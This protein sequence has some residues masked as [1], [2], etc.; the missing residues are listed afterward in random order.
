MNKFEF[1]NLTPFKWFVLENFPFIEADFDCLTEWQLFCKLGKEINKIIDSQNTVGTAME[2]FSQAFIR[3]ENYVNNYFDNLDVQEEI[4]NKL[5]DMVEQ[6]TLQEIIADYIN[7]KAIFGYDNVNDMKQATNLI[8]GSYAKTLGY[9]SKNDGGGSLYKIRNITNEDIVDEMYIIAMENEELIAEL[10]INDETNILNFGAKENDNTFDNST[11][12]NTIINK[13]ISNNKVIIPFGKFYTSNP[14]IITKSET[15]FICK[16]EINYTGNNSAIFIQK[17]NNSTYNIYSIRSSGK[18][19]KIENSEE[20]IFNLNFNI[21]KIYSED[22]CLYINGINPIFQV[23]FHCFE[24]GSVTEG[25]RQP[26]LYFTIPS[27]S[28]NS[29]V[30]EININDTMI[31]NNTETY[32]IKCVNLSSTSEIQYNMTGGTLENTTGVYSE[33]KITAV[34]FNHVRLHE[35]YN[36]TF[37]KLKGE[38]GRYAF[39]GIVPLHNTFID[40]SE[41]NESIGRIFADCGY[42]DTVNGYTH[43]GECILSNQCVI[44]QHF[45][46]RVKTL[47][48][49]NIEINNVYTQG[50]ANNFEINTNAGETTIKLDGHVFSGAFINEIMLLNYGDNAHII[51]IVDQNNNQLARFP[52]G[53]FLIKFGG[54]YNNPTID[55][56]FNDRRNE[57][58]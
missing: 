38:V 17:G 3:L 10:I 54:T 29:Y 39:R 7:S 28:T 27:T 30:N 11:I 2:T 5:N 46:S 20:R 58:S 16:G 40:W 18:A 42:R 32:G 13:N 22:N 26:N 23:N 47:S 9:Y 45:Y 51:T 12:I 57:V 35:F 4:N 34:T 33:G 14:I 1:K 25:T 37:L 24:C 8:N 6:G 15:L 49:T 48:G 19:I 52:K 36:S 41:A 55:Y 31:F 21:N 43:V 56:I 53:R 44:P 50:L